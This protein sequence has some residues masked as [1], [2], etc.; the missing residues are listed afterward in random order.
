MHLTS[1]GTTCRT[2]ASMSCL[3]RAL[4]SLST[5]N[6]LSKWSSIARLPRPV[7]NTSSVIPAAT[8]SS[9]A[10]WINGLSTTGNTALVMLVMRF[11]S[12]EQFQELRFVQYCNSKFQ[13]LVIFAAG[14]RPRNHIIGLFRHARA[15]LAPAVADSLLR[16]VALQVWQRSGQHKRFAVNR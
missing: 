8:A 10:Y 4:S 9:T 5:S 13:R 2:I 6:A 3:P 12:L 14:F 15:D 16:R 7:M 11:S 1:D